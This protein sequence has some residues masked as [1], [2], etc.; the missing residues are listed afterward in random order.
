[1]KVILYL[2]MSVNGYIAG[3][4]DEV[5]WLYSGSWDEYF[6]IVKQSDVV[7]VGRRTYEIMPPEEFQKECEYYV[8][9]TQKNI[10]K[11]ASNIFF[12]SENPKDFVDRMEKSGKVEQIMIAG[13]AKL[14]ISF[15]KNNLID[16]IYLDVE[17]IILGNGI[18]L[19]A[20]EHLEI[21]LKLLEIKTLRKDL[22]Q[23][24][25]KIAK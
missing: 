19:F 16:E 24:H 2:A 8:F 4:N 7:V 25:Y 20:P 10:T 9:T 23:L 12:T 18:S 17:P 15:L 22:L 1:M 13:G 11:K 5:D 14:N 3:K 21:K 6:K